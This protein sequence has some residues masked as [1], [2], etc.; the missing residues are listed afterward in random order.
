MQATLSKKSNELEDSTQANTLIIELKEIL[1][2]YNARDESLK[3]K[4]SKTNAEATNISALS[5]AESDKV[6]K[7]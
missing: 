1:A 2:L 4:L 6:V 3:Y 7:L 5:D